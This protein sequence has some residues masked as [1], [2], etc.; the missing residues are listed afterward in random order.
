MASSK[1]DIRMWLD[2]A[3]RNGATHM[4]VVVDEGDYEDFPVEI[5]AGENAAERIERINGAKGVRV[6]ECYKM[7]ADLESQL[8]ER[9]AYHV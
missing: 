5:K 2:K 8:N 6:I 4:L 9:R 1:N 7:D 3:A